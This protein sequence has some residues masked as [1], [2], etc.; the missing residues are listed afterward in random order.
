[1][2]LKYVLIFFRLFRSLALKSLST[3]GWAAGAHCNQPPTCSQ[4]FHFTSSISPG[5]QVLA[6]HGSSGP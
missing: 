1:M 5:R 6:N 2:L 4:F 3:I